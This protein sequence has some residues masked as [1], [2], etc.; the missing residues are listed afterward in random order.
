MLQ[1][2]HV[3]KITFII[4]NPTNP[5]DFESKYAEK[6][7][8]LLSSI[9]GIIKLETSKVH[10]KED[11]SPTP[12][13]RMIDLY[14]DSYDSACDAVKSAEAGQLFPAVFGISDK[15]LSI[16]FSEVESSN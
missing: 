7:P 4:E 6:I 12:A 14:F 16:L 11:G 15:G 2:I 10:P 9:P 13:Y 8:G 3:Y 1:F 5:A